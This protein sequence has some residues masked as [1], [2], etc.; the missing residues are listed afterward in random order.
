MGIKAAV[1]VAS[2]LLLTNC[3]H[4]NQQDLASWVGQPVSALDVHPLFLTMRRVQTITPD[5]IEIR[6]YINAS[7]AMSCSG[8]ANVYGGS[9]SFSA[10]NQF[11]SCTSSSPTC[12]N[13]FYIKEGRVLR[14]TPVGSGGAR[15]YTDER[16]RPGFSG[17]TN[18]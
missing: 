4:V 5:G 12:N 8:M 6:N 13:I 14:F 2:L 10:Y 1:A 16:A 18:F 15:C 3:A 9:V 11:M 7:D 17:A